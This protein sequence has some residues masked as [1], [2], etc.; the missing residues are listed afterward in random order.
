V[1]G[2]V[3]NLA[4]SILPTN[5]KVIIRKTMAKFDSVMSQC[6]KH[7][8]LRSKAPWFYHWFNSQFDREQRAVLAGKNAYDQNQGIGLQSSALLRRNTHRI[9]KGLSMSPRRAIF[10]QEYIVETADCFAQCIDLSHL[11]SEELSWSH[12]VLSYYFKVVNHSDVVSDANRIFESAQVSY[13][14]KYSA[15]RDGMS[16]SAQTPKIPYTKDQLIK[17]DITAAQFHSLCVQR[18]SVR[19]FTDEPVPNETLNQAITT[20]ALAP[21]ACNRQPFNFY[22]ANEAEL[23]TQVATLAGGTVGFAD[24]IPCTIVVVGDLS[25]YA[26]ERDR[27]LIYLDGALAAMQLMLALE[28]LGLSTCPINWPDIEVPEKK[29]AKLLKLE[30][31]QRP[32][33]LIAV[34]YAKECGMIPYSQ[35][36]TI[37]VLRKDIH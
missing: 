26:L 19:W 20:A 12:D 9:E 23:A 11:C 24:N 32:I 34:G 14:A 5:L 6:F 25:A 13:A 10:A 31:Y 28:T 16:L 30:A 29:M 27:H 4:R 21:S 22:V 15:T 3:K 37:A 18:R 17:S 2:I 8:L 33:M 1:F 7:P 36:K 35:K